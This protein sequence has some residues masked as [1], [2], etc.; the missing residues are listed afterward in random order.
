MN[1]NLRYICQGLIPIPSWQ[2]PKNIRKMTPDQVMEWANK[3][4][5][6]FG[7]DQLIGGIYHLD[8]EE[9]TSVG[10]VELVK[11]TRRV[12]TSAKRADKPSIPENDYIILAETEEWAAFTAGNRHDLVEN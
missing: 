6:E 9:D 3:W 5:V 12:S 1:I 10:A 2:V 11:P 4:F 8:P 7:K